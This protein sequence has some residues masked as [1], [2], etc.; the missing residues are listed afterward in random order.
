MN[1]FLP[2]S[3]L[4]AGLCVSTSG[5]VTTQHNDNSRTGQNVSET[6]LT[7]SNVNANKFGKLLTISLDGYV[8]GQPLYLPGVTFADHS[9]HNVVYVTTMHDSVYALD[10]QSG[11]VLWSRSLLQPGASTIPITTEG[12]T[13]VG[14]SEMGILGT[15]V[16]DSLTNTM[17][18]VAKAM[19]Q[20][21]EVFRIYA[22]NVTNGVDQTPNTVITG[23]YLTSSGV[24]TFLPAPQHQRPGL[25]LANTNVYVAFG[26]N[27]CDLHATGWVMAYDKG[28]L[29]QTAVFNVDSDQ[30]YGGSVWQSGKGLAADGAGNV[31]FAT[32]NGVSNNSTGDYGES[33]VRLTNSLA[34]TDYFTPYIHVSLDGGDLDFGAG[35]VVLLPDQ[36]SATPHLLVAA[37][38]EGTVYLLN[39]DNLGQLNLSADNV[40]QEIPA[41]V[42]HVTS[43]GTSPVY[44]NSNIYYAT[45]SGFRMFTLSDGTLTSIGIPTSASKASARGLPSMSANG[46][47]NGIFWILKGTSSSAPML[48]AYNATGMSLI[49][50]ST[51]AANGRDTVG[52]IV[53]FAT[54]TIIAGRVY[55]PTQAGLLIY[56]L[57]PTLKIWTGNDQSGKAGTVLPKS[58]ATK[59]VDSY[60]GAALPNVS[61]TFSDGGA[62]GSFN[63]ATTT[64]N[65][66]GVASTTY[67]LPSHPGSVH[68]TA[69]SP[70]TSTA[71]FLETAQ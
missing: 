59:A 66:V 19:E 55:V 23:T 28:S 1:R 61:V 26:S 14:F 38:K 33:V 41:G 56:G 49:Y 58:I 25:L 60:S 53:H 47:T 70:G 18:V 13:W 51:T 39:R 54:P 27:G 32:A 21:A 15:P 68:V 46:N 6:I 34:F 48:A 52:P 69:S 30:S 29:A 35:G 64:T 20:G 8:A 42:P 4:I 50:V 57:L 16:I 45:I 36:P 3:A 2:I 22:I 10:A 44:W 24:L 11:A 5:Q 37:G 31:F 17:Y 63:P 12:C 40:V 67:R 7:P 62:G 43:G 71:A 9:V 65:S